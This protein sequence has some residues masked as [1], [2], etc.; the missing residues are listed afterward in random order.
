MRTCGPVRVDLCLPGGSTTAGPHTNLTAMVA[1]VS[2]P[3][4]LDGER[5]DQRVFLFNKTFRDYES[6]LAIRGERGSPRMY[7]LEGTIEL[8]SPSIDHE[9]VKTTFARLVEAFAEER[10]IDLNGYGSWTLKRRA[11][12]RAAE[13]DECYVVGST[14]K[15]VPDFAIEVVW[16]RGGL[17]KLEIYRELGV[18][19]VWMW[20]AKRS[21]EVHALRGDRY[22]KIGRSEIIPSIDLAAIG[23][24]LLSTNQTKTVREYRASLRAKPARRG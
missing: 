5:M 24:L 16:T 19:E 13:P 10:A 3:P 14:R 7:F 20:S 18:R 9:G 4:A 2:L 17:N 12:L 21:I 1:A 6:L 23:K 8:M 15:K 22:E 11:K